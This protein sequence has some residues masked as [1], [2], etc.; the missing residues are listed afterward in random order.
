MFDTSSSSLLASIN[1]NLH[2]CEPIKQILELW[3]Q[4]KGPIADGGPYGYCLA[5]HGFFIL[6]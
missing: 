6:K 2:L 1:G 3:I 4:D 5:V